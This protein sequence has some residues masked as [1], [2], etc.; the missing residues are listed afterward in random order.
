[1][2]SK[3]AKRYAKALFELANE[4]KELEKVQKDLFQIQSTLQS[5]PELSKVLSNP[6]INN[7]KKASIVNKIFKTGFSSITS[8]L[9]KTLE[10]K[11]RLNILD[12]IFQAFDALYKKQKGIINATVTT[13]IP[14]DNRLEQQIYQ[15]IKELTGSKEIDLKKIIDPKILGGFILNVEDL[16]Y[17]ASISGKLAKIKSKLVEN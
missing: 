17:D 11:E 6:T 7:S 3:A 4:K 1:M 12:D 8:N 2:S 10:N 16:R 9:L 13:A 5:N 14:L 15:K